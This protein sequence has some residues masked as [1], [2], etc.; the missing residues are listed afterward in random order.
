MGGAGPCPWTGCLLGPHAY[1][2]E[3]GEPS[4]RAVVPGS[5]RPAIKKSLTIND[6]IA[7][8]KEKSEVWSWKGVQFGGV[9]LDIDR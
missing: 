4:T 9:H 6:S 5:A 8:F 1:K 2:T 3:V 7:F